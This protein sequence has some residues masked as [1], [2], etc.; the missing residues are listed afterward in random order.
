MKTNGSAATVSIPSLF[1][2]LLVLKL[3]GLIE[4]SWLWVL[5][6]LLWGPLVM[7]AGVITVILAVVAV[8]AFIVVPIAWIH[9]RL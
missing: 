2:I 1:V 7:F 8:F 5:T 6:S 3:F 9:D 4:I